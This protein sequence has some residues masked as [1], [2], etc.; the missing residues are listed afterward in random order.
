ME[1]GNMTFHLMDLI[2]RSDKS[3]PLLTACFLIRIALKGLHSS[4]NPYVKWVGVTDCHLT[5]L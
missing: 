5:P 2:Y 4:A 3:Y 1:I